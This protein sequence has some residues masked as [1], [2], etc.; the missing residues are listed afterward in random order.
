VERAVQKLGLGT[1]QFG[2]DYGVS[3]PAGKVP[4]TLVREILAYA[5]QTGI[6]VL[7][8]AA[9]YGNSEAVVGRVTGEHPDFAIVTKTVPVAPGDI[10]PADLKSIAEGFCASLE[11][12]RTRSVYG[13]LVHHGQ[14]LLGRG[15]E[16]LWQLL[17]RWRREGLVRKIGASVY[18]GEQALRLADRFALDLIQLPLNVFDQRSLAGGYLQKLYDRGIEVHARS[19]FLQ[20]LLLMDGHELPRALRRFAPQL[21]EFRDCAAAAG[22]TPLQAALGFVTRQPHVHV[23]LIGVTSFEQLRECIAAAACGCEIDLQRFAS[24]ETELIDPRQWTVQ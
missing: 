13:L 21:H 23:A 7:D 14:L 11:R 17:E 16:R 4:E 2:L 22:C 20:G 3:N 5:R 10:A 8:T 24:T 9:A 18:N 19:V 15:G 1:A 12:L 6:T